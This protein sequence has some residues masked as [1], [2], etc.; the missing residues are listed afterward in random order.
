MTTQV[1]STASL[2]RKKIRGKEGKNLCFFETRP[3]RSQ[4]LLLGQ[5][6]ILRG[7]QKNETKYKANKAIMQRPYIMI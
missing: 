3:S 1:H 6:N 7:F 5:C 2:E 4:A